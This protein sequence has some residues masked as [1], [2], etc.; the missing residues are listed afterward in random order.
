MVKRELLT[1]EEID[2]MR[3]GIKQDLEEKY[4]KRTF[5]LVNEDGEVVFV[6]AKQAKKRIY[7]DN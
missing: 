4:Y 2:K 3:T 5:P 6:I 1:D 7:S